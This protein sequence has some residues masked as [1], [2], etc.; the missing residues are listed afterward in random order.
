VSPKTGTTPEPAGNHPSRSRRRSDRSCGRKEYAH[1]SRLG[2][3][4]NLV[5]DPVEMS[6]GGVGADAHPHR[7]FVE[8]KPL[9]HESG[10][11]ALGR[12]ETENQRRDLE[13]L[14]AQALVAEGQQDYAGSAMIQ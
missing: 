14:L 5:E 4:A 10:E 1:Q 3:H 11:L 9:G 7:D 6:A 8:R 2:A 13:P 12:R